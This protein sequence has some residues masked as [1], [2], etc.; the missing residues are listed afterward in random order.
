MGKIDKTHK[1][2]AYGGY[3]DSGNFR[4]LT[5]LTHL[6]HYLNHILGKTGQMKFL[7]LLSEL[8]LKSMALQLFFQ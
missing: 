2:T 4:T 6:E 1:E 5:P 3:L 8:I 7:Q